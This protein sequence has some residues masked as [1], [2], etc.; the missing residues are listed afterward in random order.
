MK[1]REK[2]EKG[3]VEG[4]EVKRMRGREKK[5]RRQEGMKKEGEDNEKKKFS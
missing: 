1:T 3:M 4:E 5:E 2:T